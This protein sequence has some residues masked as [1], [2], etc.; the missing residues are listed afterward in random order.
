[1]KPFADESIAMK[2]E[3][4]FIRVILNIHNTNDGIYSLGIVDLFES[5]TIH[6]KGEICP[7]L[8]IL[9]EFIISSVNSLTTVK[10]PVSMRVK[11]V[12]PDTNAVYLRGMRLL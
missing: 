12:P 11:A 3:R 7:G 9:I 6:I 4:T 2:S 5:T 10:V 1:M 8:S